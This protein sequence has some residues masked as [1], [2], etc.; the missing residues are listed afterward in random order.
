MAYIG[1]GA[2]RSSRVFDVLLLDGTKITADISSRKLTLTEKL[3]TFLT[4]L[5]KE[6]RDSFRV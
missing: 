5:R 4:E 6:A 1:W 2:V 3:K